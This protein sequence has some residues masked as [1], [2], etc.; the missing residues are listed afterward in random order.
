MDFQIPSI[1]EAL[2]TAA[3]IN[4]EVKEQLIQGPKVYFYVPSVG[5]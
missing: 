1:Y 3:Q 2:I 5:K 4:T